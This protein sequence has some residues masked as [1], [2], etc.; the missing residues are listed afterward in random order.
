MAPSLPESRQLLPTEDFQRRPRLTA[1][2]GRTH[3]GTCPDLPHDTLAA[4]SRQQRPDQ[5]RATA[6]VLWERMPRRQYLVARRSLPRLLS[7][8]SARAT[9]LLVHR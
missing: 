8:P 1:P 7:L 6:I 9:R 2:L 3:G 4:T 5:V